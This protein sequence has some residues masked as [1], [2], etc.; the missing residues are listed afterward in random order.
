MTEHRGAEQL[1][2]DGWHEYI[3]QGFIGLAGPF[4]MKETPEGFRFCFP[5]ESKHHNRNGVVQGGALMTFSDRA[6]GATARA[7]SG[8][9]RTATVQI[10][11]QF[12]DAVQIGELVET[13]PGV[14]RYTS[15]SFFLQT[16]LM[17]AARPV[18]I[19]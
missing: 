10:D 5:T 15:N 9:S 8:A 12:V 2:A 19:V 18:A 3:D 17:V 14:V 6:L 1:R 16:T 11:F 13:S 4:F 7:V